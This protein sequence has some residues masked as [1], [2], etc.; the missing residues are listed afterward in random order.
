MDD[1]L[2]MET[3]LRA[4]LA[5]FTRASGT[6]ETGEAP[7]VTMACS[8]IQ[9]SMFNSAVLTAPVAT[10]KD[11]ERRI[12]LAAEYFRER[13]FSW[14]F[15]ICQG[16]LDRE[17]RAVVTDVFH[18][19]DL[20]LVVELPGMAADRLAPPRRAL[21]ALTFR[22]VTDATARADFNRIMSVAFGIPFPISRAVYESER[23]WEGQFVGWLGYAGEVAVTS[24]AT[25]ATSSAVGV[26][27]VGTLPTHQRKGYAEA[28]M[29]Y[30]LAETERETGI[31]R[32]VLQSSDAGY[33]LYHKMGYRNVCRYAVFASN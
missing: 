5:I 28:V 27:A 31:Q 8:G 16:W 12:R 1:F 26:Y 23:T 29:R 15:W 22:R 13:H 25:I 17:V 24:A 19:N 6:G 7:G 11:L 10:A 30:A 14:S 4:T 3:N 18:R 20:H 9:F 21:P 32:S 2:E 33:S